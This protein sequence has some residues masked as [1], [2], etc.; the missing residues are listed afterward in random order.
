MQSKPSGEPLPVSSATSSTHTLVLSPARLPGRPRGIHST[1]FVQ[2]LG[3]RAN[4][5][6]G[7]GG[8]QAG[9]VVGRVALCIRHAKTGVGGL[10]VG[11]MLHCMLDQD[12]WVGKVG[13]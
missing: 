10:V 8:R 3:S 9:G 12:G 13:R 4:G 6:S 11:G 7:G 5:G 2:E 1:M